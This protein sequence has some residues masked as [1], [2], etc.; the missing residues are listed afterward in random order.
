MRRSKHEANFQ[1]SLLP[2]GIYR[3]MSSGGI[4][5]MAHNGIAFATTSQPQLLAI[6]ALWPR[7]SHKALLW[8]TVNATRKF[9][10]NFKQARLWIFDAFKSLGFKMRGKADICREIRIAAERHMIVRNSYRHLLTR[11]RLKTEMVT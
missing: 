7:D 10:F 11:Y 3:W 4:L 6:G 5:S 1:E 9:D 8:N 2:P